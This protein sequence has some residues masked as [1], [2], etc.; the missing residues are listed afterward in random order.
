MVLNP[1]PNAPQFGA[2]GI[3]GQFSRAVVWTMH[4]NRTV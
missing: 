1:E 3:Y 2:D 4:G